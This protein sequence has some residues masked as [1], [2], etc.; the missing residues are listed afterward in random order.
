MTSTDDRMRENRRVLA[1]IT[2]T[3]RAIAQVG[4]AAGKELVALTEAARRMHTAL[5]RAGCALLTVCV[6][7]GVFGG[8]I[9]AVADWLFSQAPPP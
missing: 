2:E 1:E 4:P 5:N 6:R 8:L 3:Q 9:V 7:A